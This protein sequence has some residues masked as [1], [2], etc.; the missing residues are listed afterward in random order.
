MLGKRVKTLRAGHRKALGLS[1]QNNTQ[2]DPSAMPPAAE[3]YYAKH[4]QLKRIP[5]H[6]VR[7]AWFTMSHLLLQPGAHVGDM[8]CE[9]GAMTYVMA[10]L[11]PQIN[12]SGVDM[13]E[14]LIERAKE[15]YKLPNLR[16][17]TANIAYSAAFDREYFDA[18]INSFILHE[19]SSGSRHADRQIIKTL[20]QQFS[21]LKH[22]G[23]MYIRDFALRRPATEYVML[24]MPD[25]AVDAP[26]EGAEEKSKGKDVKSMTETELLVWYSEHA[27]PREDAGIHHGFF[28]EELPA[29]FPHTRLFR[30]PYKWAYEFIV[31][32]DDREALQAE[33]HK[34]YT[35]FTEQDFNK[36]LRMMGARVLYNAPHWDDATVTKRFDG[37]FRLFDDEG[38][39]LGPPPTSFVALAQKLGERKSLSLQERRPSQKQTEKLKVTAMRNEKTGRIVDIVSRDIDV[40]EIIPYRVTPEGQLHVFI[41]E[42]LPRGIVNAVPRNSKNLDGRLW[43]GHMVE[44]ITVPS[45]IIHSVDQGMKVNTAK[46]AK[47]YLDL[48]PDGDE[49]EHG[50]SFYPAPDYIDEIIKTRYLR[51]REHHGAIEPKAVMDEIQGFTTFGRIRELDAQKLLDAISIG[52]I[53]NS[54]LELQIVGL[55]DKLKIYAETWE[56]CPLVLE[57][58]KPELMFNAKTHIKLKAEKDQRFRK[59]KGTAGQMRSVQSTFVDEGWVE[60][61]ITG[62]ASR[63]MEFI[64]SDENTLNRAVILPLTKKDGQVMMGFEVDYLPTPQRVEGNGLTARAP[65]VTLPKEVTSVYQAR[66]Y[67]AELFNVPIDCVWRMGESYFCHAGITPQ[68]IFPFAVATRGQGSKINSGPVQFAPMRFIYQVFNTFM[69]KNDTW[70]MLLMSRTARRL[71]PEGSDLGMNIKLGWDNANKPV[72]PAIMNMTTMAGLS[73]G[74]AGGMTPGGGA[75]AGVASLMRN[76][77]LAAQ[78]APAEEQQTAQEG[79]GS[80]KKK[81]AQ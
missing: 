39:P 5:P 13:D 34:E 80:L 41:H 75:S 60:G 19:I 27:R 23:W 37:K 10:I 53:P 20:E 29:R 58:S 4:P 11:N 78:S 49:L 38:R 46:F 9:D 43:S 50:Q 74:G 59:V 68:R 25:L 70:T 22:E 73:P 65:S 14:K 55:F 17:R 35:F 44:A 32:K 6:I 71:G 26:P 69:W 57:E 77:S 52:L 48:K 28:L 8:G 79:K 40:T 36:N 31:R 54:R 66:K 51:V 24:E 3:K 33:L 47:D 81:Y 2:R 76:T 15:T 45:H 12:F 42:G 21:L 63:D 64:I 1:E 62:M 67:V 56:E 30:L 16:F 18:I 72:G 61:N 7:K